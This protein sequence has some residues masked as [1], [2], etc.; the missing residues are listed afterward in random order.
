MIKNYF[1]IISICFLMFAC[2]KKS[3]PVFDEKK[4]NSKIHIKQMSRSV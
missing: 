4:D 2:G 1:I 3:D